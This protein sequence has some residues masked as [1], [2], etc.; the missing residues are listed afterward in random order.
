VPKPESP[1]IDSVKISSHAVPATKP[2]VS[3]QKSAYTP[4]QF[5]A[6]TIKAPTLGSVPIPK[7]SSPPKSAPQLA[8]PKP[9][10]T[11]DRVPTPNISTNEKAFLRQRTKT[12]ISEAKSLLKS[13][14]PEEAMTKITEAQTIKSNSLYTKFLLWLMNRRVSS[15]NQS[16]M[17]SAQKIPPYT[18]PITR[19]TIKPPAQL[20][21][22]SVAPSQ[23][24]TPQAP[25]PPQKINAPP[26][27][28]P[29][30]PAKAP[31]VPQKAVPHQEIKQVIPPT[32][33]AKPHVPIQPALPP[34]A[35]TA[36]KEFY[37]PQINI[38]AQPAKPTRPSKPFPWKVVTAGLI[39]IIFIAILSFGL[40]YYFQKLPKPP[41]TT[42]TPPVVIT[43]PAPLIDA[44]KDITLNSVIGTQLNLLISDLY[45]KKYQTDDFQIVY[46]KKQNGQ[47]ITS[48][49]E[50]QR[51]WGINIP[52]DVN[53]NI[54]GRFTLLLYTQKD[55]SNSP[56]IAGYGQNRLALALEIQNAD[57]LKTALKN[58]EPTMIKDLSA[59]LPS[60]INTPNLRN[61]TISDRTDADVTFVKLPDST[62]ALNYILTAKNLVLTTSKATTD[63]VINKLNNE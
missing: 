44:P 54:T 2:I 39:S 25:T 17:R 27:A 3:T 6:P 4:S 62:L 7:I 60:G 30:E 23:V 38:D 49:A 40:W 52:T 46:I 45:A 59:F 20:T 37:T 32:P 61:F 12:L 57:A 11:Q 24:P 58:W 50:L 34:Q 47:Y 26:N 5:S 41:V 31:F 9:S 22:Q 56:F 21:N 43:S 53:Q 8:S 42:I 63:I 55:I 36:P 28:L 13:N 16:L 18:E 14:R 1:P 35:T 48:L 29:T 15:A 19:P 10:A 51:E 33:I